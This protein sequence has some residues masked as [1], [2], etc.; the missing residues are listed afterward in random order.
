MKLLYPILALTAFSKPASKA[1]E[2]PEE[3]KWDKDLRTKDQL[4]IYLERVNLY[5]GVIIKTKNAPQYIPVFKVKVP[6]FFNHPIVQ[7]SGGKNIYRKEFETT[8]TNNNGFITEQELIDRQLKI[9]DFMYKRV[10]ATKFKPGNGVDAT[11]SVNAISIKSKDASED[12]KGR[13]GLDYEQFALLRGTVDMIHGYALSRIHDNYSGKQNGYICVA[14]YSTMHKYWTSLLDMYD[15]PYPKS[16]RNEDFRNE[17]SFG[18]KMMIKELAAYKA[19][20]WASKIEEIL[21]APIDMS[22]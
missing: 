19:V 15:G 9:D 1:E 3:V 6:D 7:N 21:N 12:F 14:E 5:S 20:R 11:V 8:D 10:N 2:N 4:T 13:K 17:W 16:S 22:L 18:G